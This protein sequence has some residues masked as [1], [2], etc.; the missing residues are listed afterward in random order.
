MRRHPGNPPN[1]ESSY[2]EVPSRANRADEAAIWAKS[3]PRWLEAAL[4][5]ELNCQQRYWIQDYA[6]GLLTCSCKDQ[7]GLQSP[8]PLIT[9]KKPVPSTGLSF[10]LQNA[11]VTGGLL[12]RKYERT[13]AQ[14]PKVHPHQLSTTNIKK[15]LAAT[16][17]QTVEN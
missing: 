2:A 9:S 1:S 8:V 13:K 6:N 10:F 7:R 11:N 5:T 12:E 15:T 17:P 14:S 3:S 4:A 16:F